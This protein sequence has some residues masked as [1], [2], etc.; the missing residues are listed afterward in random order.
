MPGSDEILGE[1]VAV[2]P[3]MVADKGTPGLIGQ[4]GVAEVE[5]AANV[6]VCQPYSSV[7]AVPGGKESLGE[8]VA[9]DPEMVADKCWSG[10]IGQ[11]GAVEIELAADVCVRQPQHTVFAVSV[12]G[13]AVEK[14]STGHVQV[15]SDQCWTCRV[16]QCCAVQV[17][18]AADVGTGQPHRAALV[19]P[20]RS[21]PFGKHQAARHVQPI[22]D[23][24]GSSLVSQF[25]PIE[26]KLARNACARQPHRT[27][28]ARSGSNESPAEDVTIDV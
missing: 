11:F 17:E 14:D 13:E 8:H 18:L 15:I 21:E 23:K 12:A 19:M 28:L 10:G 1:H 3:E 6:G 22:S 24:C 16:D 4:L 27:K 25:G 20:S 9:V 7:W 26:I 5:L 2:D